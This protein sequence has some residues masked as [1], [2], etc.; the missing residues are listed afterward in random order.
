MTAEVP[1]RDEIIGDIA[2]L[3]G[4]VIDDGGFF[5]T[6][7][8]GSTALVGDLE[9]E[10][11]EFVSLASRLQEHYGARVDFVSYMAE[12]EIEE[13]TDLTV[14]ELAGYIASCLAAAQA[15]AAGEPETGG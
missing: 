9:L 6:E 15:R 13:L 8:S 10:S 14:G 2:R 5:D 3:V 11:I 1:G 4:E 7:I 12:L